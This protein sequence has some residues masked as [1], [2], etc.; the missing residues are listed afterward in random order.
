TE[1]FVHV[2]NARRSQLADRVLEINAEE[3]INDLWPLAENYLGSDVFRRVE[4]LRTEA[5]GSFGNSP[6]T[7]AGL[8]SELSF[9]LQ[10]PLGFIT[11]TIDKLLVTVSDSK[12]TI[13]IIDFKTNRFTATAEKFDVTAEP[14][15]LGTRRRSRRSVEG[16]FAFNFSG[17]VAVAQARESLSAEIERVAT[18]YQLQMQAYAL[19]IRQLLPELASKA[20]IRATLH[21]L[22]PNIE[23]NIE[24]SLLEPEVC[25]Q[26]LDSAM[27]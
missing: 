23:F 24:K 5:S 8:W 17:P 16:Q 26:A 3:A 7:A 18:D 4:R 2:L 12:Q 25:A 11:G 13:E 9:R 15:L 10:R 27:Q 20:R 21:F 14:E 22:Q 19:A 1:S 6:S